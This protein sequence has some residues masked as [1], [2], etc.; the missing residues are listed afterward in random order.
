MSS[1]YTN[2]SGGQS[3]SEPSGDRGIWNVIWKAKVPPKLKVFAWKAA[4]DTLAVMANVNHRIKIVSP[5]CSICGW[6]VED[7]HHALIRCTFARALREE[8]RTSWHLPSESMFSFDGKEWLLVLLQN[9]D[10]EM[11][12]KVIFLLWRVWHHRNNVVHGD[13]KASI[14]ASVPYLVNYLHSFSSNPDLLVDVKGKKP[15]SLDG[16][17]VPAD[18]DSAHVWVA[19]RPG[20]VKA[21]VDTSWD[22]RS[23]KAGFGLI[24]RDHLGQAVISEWRPQFGCISAEEAEVHAVLA[25]LKRLISL[26]RWPAILETDC[27]RIVQTLACIDMDRS[28][29]WCLLEEARELLKIFSLISVHK[30]DR[31]CNGEAHNLAQLGRSGDSGICFDATP[32]CVLDPVAN[33]LNM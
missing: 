24:I 26:G 15:I 16:P 33:L 29:S 9:L 27:L 31:R 17:H 21:N 7:G 14:S 2:L 5:L 1:I 8:L 25:G 10:S 3:S 19:P 20:V 28:A 22:A 4:T 6:E 32:N 13:G 18:P 11:R 30:V 23:G 12:A